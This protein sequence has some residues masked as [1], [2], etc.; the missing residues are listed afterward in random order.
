MKSNQNATIAILSISA[1]ILAVVVAL[2][3]NTNTG[4]ADASASAGDY[5][6]FTGE[7]S[8]SNDL[9]YVI[10]RTTFTM[11]AYEFKPADNAL[12]IVDQISLVKEFLPPAR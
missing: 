1:T 2:T 9:L 11:N 8:G 4:Y 6:M 3:C 12:R 10:D 7:V 5:I